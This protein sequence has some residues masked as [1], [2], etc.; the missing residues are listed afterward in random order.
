MT[1]Y[2]GDYAMPTPTDRGPY[3]EPISAERVLVD[4]V[5]QDSWEQCSVLLLP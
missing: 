4:N 1:G 5:I 2:I 3:C